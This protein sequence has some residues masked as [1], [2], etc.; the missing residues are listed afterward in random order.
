MKKVSLHLLCI[1]LGGSACAHLCSL[2]A[3]GYLATFTMSAALVTIQWLHCTW[4]FPLHPS[5]TAEHK[6]G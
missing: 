5:I 4:S 2:C 3:G 6:A 1:L